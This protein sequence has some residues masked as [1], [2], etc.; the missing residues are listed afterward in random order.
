MIVGSGRDPFRPALKSFLNFRYWVFGGQRTLENSFSCLGLLGQ[1]Y[2]TLPPYA[3]STPSGSANYLA[4]VYK[5][6]AALA[7]ASNSIL[8]Y[9]FGLALPLVDDTRK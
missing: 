4:G 3:P 2:P 9:L 5:V 1:N 7:V 8:Q 6:Y